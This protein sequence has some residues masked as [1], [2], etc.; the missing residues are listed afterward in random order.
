MFSS[1]IGTRECVHTVSGVTFVHTVGLR[2][3]FMQ[4][5]GPGIVHIVC[6][7]WVYVHAVI[8]DKGVCSY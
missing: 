7:V 4:I 3:V 8:G 5:V 6:V 2:C 1:D